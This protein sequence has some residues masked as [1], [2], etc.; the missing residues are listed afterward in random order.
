MG[1]RPG[2]NLARLDMPFSPEKPDGLLQNVLV[3][4][5]P[6]GMQETNHLSIFSAQENRNAISRKDHQRLIRRFR[7]KAICLHTFPG[8]HQ[9][10][11]N[12]DLRVVHLLGAGKRDGKFVGSKDAGKRTRRSRIAVAAVRRKSN[13]NL[14]IQP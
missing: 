11:D 3:D 9:S 14:I 12:R 5:A 8:F 7:E 10:R 2:Q 6:S 4:P 13:H 1:P